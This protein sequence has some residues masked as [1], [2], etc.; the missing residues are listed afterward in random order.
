MESSN[1]YYYFLLKY[2]WKGSSLAA[3]RLGLQAFTAVTQDLIPGG[4]PKDP[5]KPYS[6][7]KKKKKKYSWFTMYS[8]MIPFYI[9]IHIYILLCHFLLKYGW[10]MIVQQRD[11]FIPIF[12][13]RFF[14]IIGYYKILN[15]VPC[16]IY[17]RS[18]DVYLIYS[19]MYT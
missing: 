18:L 11:S 1:Y 12:F 13:Y 7:K 19:S 3:Q 16:A 9:Y 8:K 2:T 10:F 14:S 15:I 5:H 17:N 6:Q 4:G